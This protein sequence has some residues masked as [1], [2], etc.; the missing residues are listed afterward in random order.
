MVHGSRGLQWIHLNSAGADR[1]DYKVLRERNVKV[2]TSSGAADGTVAISA[3]GG[4][5]ALARHFPMLM[6]AQ[7]RRAWE[8][9]RDERTPRDLLARPR[10]WSAQSQSAA[11]SRAC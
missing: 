7:R 11:R 8:P 1:P 2:V 9:L 10:S 3:V 5:I 4:M 6:E